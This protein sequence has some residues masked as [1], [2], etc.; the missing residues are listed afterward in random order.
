M[1]S[2]VRTLLSQLPMARN[3]ATGEK[4]SD[5]IESGGESA[6]SISFSEDAL[7]TAGAL[8]VVPKKAMVRVK[9]EA[10]YKT[11]AWLQQEQV[12]QSAYHVSV[13]LSHRHLATSLSL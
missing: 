3:S 11:R 2:H 5:E 9:G 13:R 12:S 10:K 4:A 6:T 1:D 8:E 7:A